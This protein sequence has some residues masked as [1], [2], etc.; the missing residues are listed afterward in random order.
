MNIQATKLQLIKSISATEN[1]EFLTDLFNLAK[2][3]FENEIQ[4]EPIQ[5]VD[6]MIKDL[7][8]A[9]EDIREGRVFS[10]EEAMKR[11]EKWL[12]K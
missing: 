11:A 4:E 7:E 6:W 10:H 3:K 8:E 2:T 12:E 5:L 9:E 1:Q